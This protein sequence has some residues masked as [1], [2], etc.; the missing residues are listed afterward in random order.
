MYLSRRRV[1]LDSPDLQLYFHSYGIFAHG[2]ARQGEEKRTESQKL[3]LLRMQKCVAFPNT[4]SRGASTISVM[5]C[6]PQ[7]L[8]TK[9]GPFAILSPAIR[10]LAHDYRTLRDDVLEGRVCLWGL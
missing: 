10:N 9:R 1:S 7:N 2:L 8:G 4:T 6:Q 5:A 3:E